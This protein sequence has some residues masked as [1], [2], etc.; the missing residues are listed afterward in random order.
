MRALVL[1]DARQP[2]FHRWG[3]AL[4]AAGAEVEGVSLQAP[5]VP[6]DFPVHVPAARGP[7]FLRYRAALPEVLERA[8]EFGP[9]LVS[10]LFVPDY[11]LLGSLLCARLEPRPALWVAP[12]GSDVLR[13]AWRTP[14]H[15]LRARRV[16]AQAAVVAVDAAVL[17]RGVAA[18]GVPASRVARVDWVPDLSRFPYRAGRPDGALRV[19]S[20]RQLAPVYDV[21][22]LVR[23]THLLAQRRAGFALTIAGDGPLR[24]AL[25]RQAAPL[26]GVAHFVGRLDASG[27]AEALRSA[28]VYVSTSRADSTSVSLL[29]AMACGCLPVVTDIDGNREWVTEG[30]SGLLFRPGDAQGLA[31]QLARALDD[32]LLRERVAAYNRRR[33]ESLPGFEERVRQLLGNLSGNA[34]GQS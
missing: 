21:A 19:V 26:R 9:Q 25:E 13:N 29:E 7:A 32:D 30:S 20:T 18:L 3:A 31:R 5:S 10:A 17:A 33:L 6:P 27:V 1:G 16:L 2:H 23:A 22:T 28:A 11:G 12:L 15:W 8:R 14:M 24:E 34:P 4:R